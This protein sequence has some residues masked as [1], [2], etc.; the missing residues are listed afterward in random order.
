MQ[1]ESQLTRGACVCVCKVHPAGHGA[2]HSRQLMLP[3]VPLCMQMQTRTT[4]RPTSETTVE[5]V[6]LNRRAVTCTPAAATE[7]YWLQPAM[8]RTELCDNLCTCALGVEQ[9]TD[10]SMDR[11]L[12]RLSNPMIAM[13]RG[14]WQWAVWACAPSL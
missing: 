4:L 1:Q 12:L 9:C 6:N 11:S 10:W 13:S 3:S 5:G 8:R 7:K 2:Q 14:F